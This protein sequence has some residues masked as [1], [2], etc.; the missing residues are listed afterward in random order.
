MT[1]Q[2]HDNRSNVFFKIFFL[3]F[4]TI[5]VT[6][7]IQVQMQWNIVSSILLPSTDFYCSF[8]CQW[9]KRKYLS[10]SNLITF[11]FHDEYSSLLVHHKRPINYFEEQLI[12]TMNYVGCS[13]K[14][15]KKKSFPPFLSFITLLHT[16]LTFGRKREASKW[17]KG[18]RFC[19][20][21][22][23]YFKFENFKRT[24]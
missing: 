21:L 3:N 2:F 14:R 23:K 9:L 16:E 19:E 18:V 24:N 20:M 5:I 8:Y 11:H 13:W 1:N 12:L 22:V 15:Q 10:I 7:G 4:S 17:W 6:K